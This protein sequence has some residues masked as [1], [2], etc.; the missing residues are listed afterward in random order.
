MTSIL[1]LIYLFTSI[2]VTTYSILFIYDKI[3]LN[4]EQI[5]KSHF[6]I[7]CEENNIKQKIHNELM[8]QSF[9]TMCDI[10]YFDQ[11]YLRF[12]IKQS[13]DSS[14]D[15]QEKECLDLNDDE[16]INGIKKTPRSMKKLDYLKHK[17][18]IK[19]IN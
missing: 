9:H 6:N 11:E 3:I 2:F 15:Y 10:L 7:W 13:I 14:W 1:N 5:M 12:E 8:K 17:W 19:N 4:N 16:I 18:V